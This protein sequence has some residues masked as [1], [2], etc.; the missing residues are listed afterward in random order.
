MAQRCEA[1][2]QRLRHQ[3][4][5]LMHYSP[6]ARINTQRQSLD[7]LMYQTAVSISQKMA[8]QRSQVNGLIARLQALNPRATLERGYAVV[9]DRTT[10]RI[11]HSVGQVASG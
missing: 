11:V 7:T 4:Q 6:Q 3:Q 8:L 9:F 2:G 10:G 5:I 1:L